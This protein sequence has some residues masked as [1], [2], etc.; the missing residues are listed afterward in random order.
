MWGI[1]FKPLENYP[2]HWVDCELKPTLFSARSWEEFYGGWRG[3]ITNTGDLI[4]WWL[5]WPMSYSRKWGVIISSRQY[6]L[7][8]LPPPSRGQAFNTC[9]LLGHLRS[10][11]TGY[12]LPVQYMLNTGEGIVL[13]TNVWKYWK[14]PRASKLSGDMKLW[15][16]ERLCF[17]LRGTLMNLREEKATRSSNCSNSGKDEKQELARLCE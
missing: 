11:P 9:T 16:D 3:A 14:S 4:L 7:K 15:V 8:G 1:L 10:R 17:H 12:F 2:A 6:L 5:S 13:W